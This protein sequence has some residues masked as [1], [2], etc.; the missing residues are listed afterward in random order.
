MIVAVVSKNMLYKNRLLP[1][2]KY[3]NS[4]F[5]QIKFSMVHAMTIVLMEQFQRKIV[6][7]QQMNLMNVNVILNLV[8]GILLIKRKKE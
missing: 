6:M 1:K 3:K 7:E 2:W 5:A 8:I 4:G